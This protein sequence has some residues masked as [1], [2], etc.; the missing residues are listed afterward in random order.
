MLEYIDEKHLDSEY[1]KFISELK[2]SHSGVMLFL[3]VDMDLSN[4]ASHFLISED[5]DCIDR[6]EKE[7]FE[8]KTL[9]VR[10]P[11]IKDPSLKNDGKY[12]IV[13][14]IFS[15]YDWKNMWNSGPDG[16]RTPEYRKLK[17][18][19]MDEMIKKIETVIP[20]LKEKIEVKLLATPLTFDRYV[21]VSEGAW[22]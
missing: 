19:L 2:Q 21:L 22:F 14:F 11:A 4:F 8:I 12:S 5:I 13:A 15:P 17:N 9:A 1:L 3:G 10:I 6:I 16:K 18:D 20:G 7:I